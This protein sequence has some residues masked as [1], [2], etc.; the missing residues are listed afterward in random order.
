MAFNQLYYGLLRLITIYLT[1]LNTLL[2]FVEEINYII[3][4]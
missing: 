3:S 2:L 1:E 4:S